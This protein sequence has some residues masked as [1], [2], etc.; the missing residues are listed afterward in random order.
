M[1]IGTYNKVISAT[2]PSDSH[3]RVGGRGG[4]AR[5]TGTGRPSRTIIELAATDP[6][7]GLMNRRTFYQ[8]VERELHR[9]RRDGAPVAMVYVD[10][11]DL[12]ARNDTY[13]HEAGD[14]MIVAVAA[15]AR[16]TF[17]TTDL[18]AR[19][20]GDE[21]AFL[22]PATDLDAADAAVERL[23]S[24][25]VD[26]EPIPIR[27]SAGIVAGVVADDVDPEWLVHRADLLMIEAK[28]A[29]KGGAA[30]QPWAAASQ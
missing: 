29:G 16:S 20:G 9:A 12:K 13:G 25:L 21:F 24:R 19:L 15:T 11:D 23:R 2:K 4:E 26:A 22:L 5:P 14:E 18:L 30:S 1:G 6:L 7:T 27:F 17:R 10:V 8:A 28:G 3:E